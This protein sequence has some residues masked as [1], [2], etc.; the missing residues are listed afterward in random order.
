MRATF[1]TWPRSSREHRDQVV[2][3]QPCPLDCRRPQARAL[4]LSPVV[5]A[6]G[7]PQAVLTG[8]RCACGQER[9]PPTLMGVAQKVK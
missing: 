7:T 5:R 1:S 9:G 8:E 3:H 6:P 2:E 4:P